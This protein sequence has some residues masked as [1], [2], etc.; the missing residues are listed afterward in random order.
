MSN[1]TITVCTIHKMEDYI[2]VKTT[3][4]CMALSR[5]HMVNEHKVRQA[6]KSDCSMLLFYLRR[7]NLKYEN[8]CFS[9]LSE[10]TNH[11]TLVFKKDDVGE[12]KQGGNKE[13]SGSH[14]LL[15]TPGVVDFTP[16]ACKHFT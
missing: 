6:K 5:K 7:E 3:G 14:T 9:F 11:E 8:I 2:T 13:R 4:H 10:R 15:N 12:R 16:E 1:I